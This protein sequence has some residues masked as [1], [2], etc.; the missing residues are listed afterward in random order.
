[1]LG[2]AIFRKSC[3]LRLQIL[4]KRLFEDSLSSNFREKNLVQNIFLKIIFF[5]F[6]SKS[7]RLSIKRRINIIACLS[8]RESSERLENIIFCKSCPLRLQIL[9]KK[10]FE[11]SLSSIFCEKKGEQ[12]I[13]LKIFFLFFA[14]ESSRLSIKK[15]ITFI[16]HLGPRESSKKLKHVFLGKVVRETTKSFKKTL[17]EISLITI[18][19]LPKN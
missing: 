14:S 7:P 2:N 1:M 17:F 4:Q 19:H 3:P 6:A 11:N 16:G 10:P 5:F 15:I 12:T 9:Q 8:P 13:F 18:F